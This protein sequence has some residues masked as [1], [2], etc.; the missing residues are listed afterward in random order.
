MSISSVFLLTFI[1]WPLPSPRVDRARLKLTS[2]REPG[3]FYLC[4]LLFSVYLIND[5]RW[6]SFPVRLFISLSFLTILWF[7]H[8]SIVRTFAQHKDDRRRV[9]KAFIES[10]GLASGKVKTFF[11]NYIYTIPSNWLLCYFLRMTRFNFRSLHSTT[12]TAFTGS[13]W[14]ARK[15]TR[16]SRSCKSPEGIEEKYCIITSFSFDGMT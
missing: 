16:S 10:T 15:L 14:A 6:C 3:M 7:C 4:L 12:F 8:G 13:W 9:E 5:W 2:H 11:I 1:I